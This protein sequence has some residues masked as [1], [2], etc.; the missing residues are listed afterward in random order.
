MFIK[1]LNIRFNLS[2]FMCND[3][4][5]KKFESFLYS[6]LEE[7]ENEMGEEYYFRLISIDFSSI[8]NIEVQNII[9][10]FNIDNI[11]F[12]QAIY[13]YV[14]FKLKLIS[15]KDTF[16]FLDAIND[17]LALQHNPLNQDTYISMLG[18]DTTGYSSEIN[19][20]GEDLYQLEATKELEKILENIDKDHSVSCFFESKIIKE[21]NF[22]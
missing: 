2:S 16:N 10:D 12:D 19:R 5:L 11:Y 14:K 4:C 18:G 9:Y 21:N 6:N 15:L 13:I 1:N 20:L 17:K 8:S 7:F 3:L 22:L